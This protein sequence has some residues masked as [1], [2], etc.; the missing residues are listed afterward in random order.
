M[1]RSSIIVLF[2]DIRSALNVGAMLRT[3]DAIRADRVYLCGITATPKHPKVLKTSLGA[4]HSVPWIYT[5]DIFKLIARLKKKGFQIV[6]LELDRRSVEFWST[7]YSLKTAI[8]VG[9]E[10]DGI[11]DSLLK[12]CDLVVSI[13]MYGKK[14]SLNVATAFGIAA[15][16]ILH[17]QIIANNKDKV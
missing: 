6:G 10:I 12:L 8:I 5:S 11:P 2:N 14:E 4:E 15:Y 13:P 7:N 1:K 16:E 3:A 9:N 17:Q